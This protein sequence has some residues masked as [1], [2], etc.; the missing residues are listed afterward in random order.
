MSRHNWTELACTPIPHALR[1]IIVMCTKQLLTCLSITVVS[2]KL[3][4]K[5]RLKVT[6][7]LCSLENHICC[8]EWG[9][10]ML[11]FLL[12]FPSSKEL[13]KVSGMM[14]SI[15]SEAPVCTGLYHQ[16]QQP[17]E[18]TNSTIK[19]SPTHH[20]TTTIITTTTI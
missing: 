19:P 2:Q 18:T 13:H 1:L 6:Y 12:I 8:R 11:L 9:N 16:Q 4:L 14:S 20:N 3:Y 5:N 15:I 17:Y 7:Q 10:Y